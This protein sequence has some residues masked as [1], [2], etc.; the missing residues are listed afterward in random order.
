MKILILTE[1]PDT[2]RRWSEMVQ[3]IADCLWHDVA[4]IPAR[5]TPDVVLLDAGCEYRGDAGQIRIGGDGPADVNL[6]AGVEERELQLVCRLLGEIVRLRRRQEADA[7]LH[8][9]LYAET[10]TDPLTGLPN[11]RAWEQRLGEQTAGGGLHHLCLAIFDLDR[12]KQVNDAFGHAAGD[13]VLKTAGRAI[14]E[15]LRQGDFVARVGGDE[16]GLLLKVSDPAVALAVIERVRAVLPGKLAE[17]GC[18]K[19][20]AS[21]GA[22]VGKAGESAERLFAPADEALRRAKRDGRDRTV[23]GDI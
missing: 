22:A 14:C 18:Q 21:A 5:E 20:T 7:A 15:N 10:L 17:A 4:E 6:P 8:E 12:F 16:F 3:P 23:M 19:I 1:N 11:R 2:R 13:A 9:R